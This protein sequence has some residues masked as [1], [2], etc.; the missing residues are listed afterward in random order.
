MTKFVVFFSKVITATLLALSITS[1]NHTINFGN[2]ITGT[3]NVVTE[4]RNTGNF[5][6]VSVAN[7]L[8]CEVFLSDKF[9]VT[10]EADD[11]LIKGIKTVVENGT[12]IITSEYSN[13]INVTSKKIIVR[14]PKVVSLESTSGSTLQS[15]NLLISDDLT[16]KS[17]SGSS[18]EAEV[19]ADK[20]TLETSSG[21][22]QKVIGKALK[23]YSASS[24][25]SHIDANEL[26]A[27][28]VNAQSSSGSSTSVNASLLLDA[29]ASSG[30]SITY[31]NSPKEV[32]KEESSG[33]SVS[34]D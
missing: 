22:E 15:G 6:K 25:G 17:S 19:E 34:K 3:G 24:S 7:G 26:L 4:K 14:L 8:E 1:C 30:S 31:L 11:N 16:L 2:S 23:V 18:L 33:G 9:E 27:N 20:V 32:R 29:K 28:E 13:Y 10:V 21:S 12:L 5:D